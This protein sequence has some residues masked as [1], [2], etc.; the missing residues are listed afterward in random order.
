MH[1]WFE[2]PSAKP[3]HWR[4]AKKAR[5]SSMISQYHPPPPTKTVGGGGRI[6]R[7]IC[8][9]FAFRAIIW[10][11]GVKSPRKMQGPWLQPWNCYRIEVTPC[12]SFWPF[13]FFTAVPGDHGAKG[14]LVYVLGQP[15]AAAVRHQSEESF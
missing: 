6:S 14:F 11:K 12:S 9:F 3:G 5:T 4:K 13:N 7:E 1:G 2:G 15:V 8:R 10:R